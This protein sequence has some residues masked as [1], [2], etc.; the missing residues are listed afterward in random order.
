MRVN[1]FNILV[2]GRK[3]SQQFW[4]DMWAKVERLRLRWARDN[5]KK[6]KAERYKGLMDAQSNDDLPNAGRIIILPASITGSPR[7]YVEQLMDAMAIVRVFGK[8]TLFLTL[9]TNP[10]WMDIVDS[11]EEGECA[12]DRPDIVARVFNAKLGAMMDALVKRNLL[13]EV[14]Y[15]VYTIEWQKRRGLPHCHCLLKLRNEPRTPAEVDA[16]IS[17]EIPGHDDPILRQLVIDHMIHGPCGQLNRNCVCMEQVCHA[18]DKRLKV[19]K[20]NAQVGDSHRRECK[21]GFPFTFAKETHLDDDTFP[22]Y[23]RRSP[24]DGGET[25]ENKMGLVVDNRWVVSFNREILLMW[26]GHANLKL[27]VSVIGVKYVFKYEFKVMIIS[28]DHLKLKK[29]I[30]LRGPTVSS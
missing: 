21:I 6:L 28:Y 14:V 17:A 27:V 4:V 30:Q 12:F 10:R 5:Q 8:P 26:E 23:M 1:Q 16:L 15:W 3:L 20:R 2:R 18:P 19:Q 25:F 29:F 9:T 24:E 13:G 11:L 7:W 22:V